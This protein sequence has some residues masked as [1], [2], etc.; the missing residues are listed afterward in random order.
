MNKNRFKPRG[1]GEDITNSPRRRQGKTTMNPSPRS[2][3]P[4]SSIHFLSSCVTLCPSSCSSCL[5]GSISS[6]ATKSSP[7]RHEEHEGRRQIQQQRHRGK[8]SMNPSPRSS[9]P[10][11]STHFLSSCVTLCSPLCSSCLRGKNSPSSSLL[12]GSPFYRPQVSPVQCSPV[13][14]SYFR[15]GFLP[16]FVSFVSSW[17]IV[18]SCS[19]FFFFAFFAP[20]RFVRVTGVS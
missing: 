19:F 13:F 20:S 2:S 8:A 11:S 7:R 15:F 12:R 1:P 17:F 18:F 14:P 3:L 10:S 16:L 5:R 9:L 4:S 6:E